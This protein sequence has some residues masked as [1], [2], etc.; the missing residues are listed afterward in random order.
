[1]PTE[2]PLYL[3]AQVCFQNKPVMPQGKQ[4]CDMLYTPAFEQRERTMLGTCNQQQNLNL[5]I[6][7]WI[8]KQTSFWDQMKSDIC[9][10]FYIVFWAEENLQ[11]GFMNFYVVFVDFG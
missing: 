6:A 2:S 7:Y 1:M 9:Y 11:R 8:K 3:A 5:V 10:D 4:K